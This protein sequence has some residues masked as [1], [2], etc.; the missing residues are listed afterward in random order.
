MA[1]VSKK[2]GLGT[3]KNPIQISTAS[4]FKRALLNGKRYYNLNKD[5]EISENFTAKNFSGVIYG[6]GHTVKLIGDFN[7]ALITNLSGTITS[8]KFYLNENDIKITQNSA[9]I[10]EKLS[11]IIENC[12]I[13][14]NFS[15]N[16]AGD[17]ALYFGMCS[18][19]NFGKISNCKVSIS[20]TLNNLKETD[21]Y[22]GGIAGTNTESGEIVNCNLDCGVVQADTVDLAGIVCENNGKVITCTN[23]MQLSQTSS[24]EWHPNVAGISITNNGSIEQCLNYGELLAESTLAESG[25]DESGEEYSYSVILGGVV[26]NNNGA[27]SS[28]ENHGLLSGNG[29]VPNLIAGGISAINY[30][31]IETSKNYGEINLESTRNERGKDADGDDYNYYVIAGGI[32]GNN[33]NSISD[34][35]NFGLVSSKGNVSNI[36]V[37]GLVAQNSTTT[38]L[39]GVVQRSL[40]K[41]NI[42]AKSEAGQVCVG[43]AV[44]SNSSYVLN[45]GFVGEIDA[46]SN[47]KKDEQI[48][49]YKVEQAIV[50]F[51][52][53]VVGVNNDAVIRNCYSDAIFKDMVESDE[54]KKLQAG[55]VSMAGIINLSY[56]VTGLTYVSN[57]Y[58]IVK[59]SIDYVCFGIEGSFLLNGASI[60]YQSGTIY[61]I[62]NTDSLADKKMTEVISLND[63]PAG[64]VIDE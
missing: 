24:K 18:S 34:S 5:I 13:N 17:K 15:L 48:F 60:Q 8:L 44:G 2:N 28:S 7:S 4:E 63:I 12:E 57:N 37:G 35:R 16:F 58:Y 20:S 25:K 9:I 56:Y 32:T 46:D 14:G 43:G 53:G 52:G 40:A 30:G 59:E 51:A 62:T 61:S 6:N 29:I 50:V 1:V 41:N 38:N 33:F 10:T 36:I 49:T 42:I 47:S 19:E 45:C 23:K 22:F 3:E 11:G 31:T 27:I 26:C 39:Y 64:V 54:V 55:V 21:A